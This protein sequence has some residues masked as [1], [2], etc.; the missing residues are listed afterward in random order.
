M[1]A[2]GVYNSAMDNTNGDK[3]C[4]NCG[5]KRIKNGKFCTNCGYQLSSSKNLQTVAVEKSE[6]ETEMLKFDD[7]HP[8]ARWLFLFSYMKN[9]LV[10]LLLLLVSAMASL[11]SGDTFL[12]LV[13]FGGLGVYIIG[14]LAAAQIAYKHYSFQV[15]DVAF[16]KQF[17]I[18]HI[19]TASIPFERIQNVNVRRTL[20]DRII[21]LSH[22]DIETAGTGGQKKSPI[23]GGKKSSAEGH[24]PGI[25]PDEAEKVR[26]LIM[27]RAR[28]INQSNVSNL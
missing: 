22:V 8:N 3:F 9:T 10:L 7:L 21:G 16:R 14:H 2:K 17:G 24:I 26:S 15:T 11:F 23:I 20:L 13:V 19:H 1:R 25:S 18:L 6:A 28:D 4:P 5:A 27:K 12:S